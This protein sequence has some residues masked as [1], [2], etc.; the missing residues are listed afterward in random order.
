MKITHAVLAASLFVSFSSLAAVEITK[1]QAEKYQNIGTVSITE[2]GNDN[3]GIDHVQLSKAVDEKGGKYYVIVAKDG[4]EN[5]Q[6]VSAI[7]YK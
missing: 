6:N 1:E 5:R 4:K 3:V 7:A 2:T